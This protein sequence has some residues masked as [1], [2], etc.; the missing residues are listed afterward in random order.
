LLTSFLYS[1]ALWLDRTVMVLEQDEEDHGK[2]KDD[3]NR[4]LRQLDD[5]TSSDMANDEAK[6]VVMRR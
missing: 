2:G 3:F 5:V 6:K 1:S 4:S